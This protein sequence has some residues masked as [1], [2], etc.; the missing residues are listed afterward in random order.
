MPDHARRPVALGDEVIHERLAHRHQRKFGRDEEPVGQ[1]EQ[2]DREAQGGEQLHR[3]GDRGAEPGEVQRPLELRLDDD[4]R[5]LRLPG[6][7][8]ERLLDGPQTRQDDVVGLVLGQAAG[9]AEL[10]AR[11]APLEAAR[12][13]APN[14][15]V[16][17]RR[18]RP[19][20]E[21]VE[22]RQDRSGTERHSQ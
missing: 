10:E 15:M 9:G 21:P 3:G 2:E 16:P 4:V 18:G 20:H 17:W 14:G 8:D 7:A 12:Q 11:L 13:R 5:D 6:A 19:G 22:L 1:D